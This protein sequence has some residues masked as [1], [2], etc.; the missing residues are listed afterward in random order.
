M[1]KKQLE[2]HIINDDY[3][4]TLATVLNLARQTLEKDMR[5]PKKN[6]HIKLLQSLEE[7]LMYLQQNYKITKK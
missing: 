3:F 5:G 2:N 7:D 1:H 6:W 4:G